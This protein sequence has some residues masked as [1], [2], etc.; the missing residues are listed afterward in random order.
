MTNSDMSFRDWCDLVQMNLQDHGVDY[1]DVE[2]LSG[3]Y[4]NGKDVMEVVDEI[5]QE[6]E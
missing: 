4:H 3:Y 6:Y 5:L 2:S 1:D